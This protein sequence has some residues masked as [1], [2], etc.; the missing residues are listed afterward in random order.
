MRHIKFPS[1]EQFRNVVKNVSHR[2]SYVGMDDNGDA[3]FDRL[4]PKPTLKFEGTVKLHGSNAAY[5]ESPSGEYWF[6][7]RENIIT[8]E[9][10]NAGFAMFGCAN[11][12]ILKQ[13]CDKIKQDFKIPSATIAVFGE[14][15]GIGI[16][17]NVAISQIDKSFFVFAIKVV[18]DEDHSYF[19]NLDRMVW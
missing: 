8:P 2:A 7:S 17:K 12:N 4:A 3:I 18:L 14:F 9:K 6:Q 15:V 1:I 16:Q 11:L 10:D 13:L 19:I 5:L